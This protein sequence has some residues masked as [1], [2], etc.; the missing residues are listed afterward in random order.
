MPWAHRRCVLRRCA[1]VLLWIRVS[2]GAVRVFV[3]F[4]PPGCLGP[5]A[6]LI[7]GPGCA[8]LAFVAPPPPLARHALAQQ[9]GAD[10]IQEQQAPDHPRLGAVPALRAR[11]LSEQGAL[12]SD[13]CYLRRQR[14]QLRFSSPRSW[15]L[16]VVQ[17]AVALDLDGRD[18][19]LLLDGEGACLCL[20]RALHQE[21]TV[22]RAPLRLLRF[23]LPLA[24]A[25]HPT[26]WHGAQPLPLLMPM[27]QLLHQAHIA[28]APSATSERLLE[29]L[30]SYC[31]TELEGQ[32]VRLQASAEDPLQVLLDWLPAHLDQD[33][34]LADLAAAACLSARRLQELCQQRFG[35]TP[36]ELLRE[37]R[38]EAMHAQLLDPAYAREA[39]AQLYRRWQLPDSAATRQAFAARYGQTPQALRKQH[40]QAV[41]PL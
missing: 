13:E 8:A 12:L 7:F 30:Q 35:C 5:A 34:H 10:L 36:M 28:Q 38:L 29:A 11:V 17:G 41:P 31:A 25:W 26:D 22:L 9:L 14:Y 15:L 39:T 40:R 23:A 37:Q 19:A 2:V 4:P 20:T 1:A 21:F 18:D 6:P 16:L 33:L 3:L 32:G 24:H 27:L